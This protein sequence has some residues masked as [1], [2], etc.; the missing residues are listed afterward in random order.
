MSTGTEPAQSRGPARRALRLRRSGRRKPPAAPLRGAAAL[1][2]GL[3]PLRGLPE[4]RQAPPSGTDGGACCAKYAY[5]TNAAVSRAIMISSLVG[6][7]QTCTLLSGPE[8]RTSSP[9]LRLASLSGVTP[10]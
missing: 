8:M 5:C 9:R 1:L 3:P 7:T 6:T 2:A 10:R 4:R